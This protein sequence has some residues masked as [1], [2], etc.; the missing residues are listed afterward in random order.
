MGF[1]CRVFGHKWKTIYTDDDECRI[2]KTTR[3][4]PMAS[5]Q[6]HLWNRE[7]QE[8]RSKLNGR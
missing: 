3:Y 2:C 4:W 5:G 7:E 8:R 6:E 1:M